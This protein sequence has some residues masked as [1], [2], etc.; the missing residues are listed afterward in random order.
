MVNIGCLSSPTRRGSPPSI[1]LLLCELRSIVSGLGIGIRQSALLIHTYRSANAVALF[2][3]V[4]CLLTTLVEIHLGFLLYRNWRAL[5][6][7][8]QSGGVD[9]A[10]VI[11]TCV[12]GMYIAA[13]MIISLITIWNPTTSITDLY[14]ASSE[15]FSHPRQRLN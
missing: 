14:G 8:G 11:R 2:S 6:A 4:I 10:F 13:G 9:L 5:R 12:F 3:S 1:L 15:Y 7:A